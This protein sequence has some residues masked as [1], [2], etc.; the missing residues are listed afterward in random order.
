MASMIP[1]H[2]S[3]VTYWTK[4]L[5]RMGALQLQCKD[6][7]K[8]YSLTMYGSKLLTGSERVCGEVVILED[9][10]VKFGVLEGEKCRIEW[11][12]LGS[13]RNWEKLGVRIGDVR[14]VRTSAS[15][16]IHPG[17]LRGFDPEMLKV[18]AGQIV[19]HVKAVLEG[20]FGMVLSESGVPLHAPI[21][22][23]YS[24]EAKEDVK[25]GTTIVQ[26]IGSVD[27]SPPERVP[28][29]EYTGVD[30]ARARLMLPDQVRRLERKVDELAAVTTSLA[31]SV[32]KLVDMFKGSMEPANVPRPLASDDYA[33]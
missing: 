14:V 18:E 8:L 15:V 4:K 24:E 17:R 13:P 10:A 7:V 12:R 2:K 3:N 26:G 16:I 29:E 28:H 6:V 20:R 22:R 33:R 5:S 23:F 21:V 1:C 30:R 11:V 32:E 25:F 19:G 27:R 31:G 9:C